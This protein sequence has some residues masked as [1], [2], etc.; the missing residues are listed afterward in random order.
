MPFPELKRVLYRKNPLYQVI[1]QLRFPPILRI[2]AEIPANFQERVRRHFPN[3][4]ETSWNVEAP[5][6]LKGLI[7]PEFIQQALQ[8]SNT[9]NYEFSSEDGQW[10]INLTRT[11]VALSTKQYERWE[12]FKDKLQIPLDALVEVYSP[13]DFSR[14]GLRYVDIIRRSALNLGDVHWDELLQPYILGLLG[15]PGV[16]TYVKNFESKYEVGLSDG[17]SMVQII[18]RF[19]GAEDN[20]EICYIIDSDFYNVRKTKIDSVMERLD[21]FNVRASRLIQWCISERLHQA[22]EPQPL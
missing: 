3:F 22:M 9:K 13:D 20:G 17:E 1:C 21:Y 14:V 4:A 8:L 15:S 6:D 19:V 16:G 12:Q 7:P 18:T 2:D 5:P 10:K 11:F